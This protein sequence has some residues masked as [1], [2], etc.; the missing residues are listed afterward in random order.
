MIIINKSSRIT[1]LKRNFG[2]ESNKI[3]IDDSN[4][5]YLYKKNQWHRISGRKFKIRDKGYGK[6]GKKNFSKAS[7]YDVIQVFRYPSKKKVF[8][9]E[10]LL[11]HLN[12]RKMDTKIKLPQYIVFNIVIP[13][14][15]P[16]WVKEKTNGTTMMIVSVAEITKDCEN[17]WLNNDKSIVADELLRRFLYCPVTEKKH[18]EN[19]KRRLKCINYQMNINL[20]KSPL[21]FLSANLIEKYNGVPFLIRDSSFFNTHRGFVCID[22]DVNKFGYVARNSLWHLNELSTYGIFDICLIVEGDIDSDDSELPENVI[23]AWRQSRTKL[24][25]SSKTFKSLKV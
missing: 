14:Y 7:L 24:F 12:F 2:L 6:H 10:H 9:P 21:N 18:Y 25:L 22:I 19:I 20:K 23:C 8:D 16:A 1:Y 11:N 5:E 17:R 3:Q 13:N 15:K 4:T